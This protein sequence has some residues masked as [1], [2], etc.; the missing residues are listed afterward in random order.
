ME[1]LA[2]NLWHIFEVCEEERT[3][4]DSFS[5]DLVNGAAL[6]LAALSG[7]KD[8]DYKCL[9]NVDRKALLAEWS[10]ADQEKAHREYTALVAAVP[11]H[12]DADKCA[13]LCKAL[14]KG[15]RKAFERAVAEGLSK[16]YRNEVD[17]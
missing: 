5:P 8:T 9:K 17:E 10:K 14:Q 16:L 12:R 6:Y 13:E 1:F 11:G 15:D 7:A 3:D 2:K 4:G